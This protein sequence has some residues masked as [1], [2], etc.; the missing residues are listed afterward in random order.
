[1][2]VMH[3][4][5]IDY[6]FGVPFDPSKNHLRIERELSERIMRHFSRFAETG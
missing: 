2:G 5:E 3:G 4:D 6:V 1:M